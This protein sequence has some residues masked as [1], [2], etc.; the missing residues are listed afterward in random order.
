VRYHVIG[1]EDTVLGFR[2]AGVTGDVVGTADEARA[3]LERA[4]RQSDVGIVIIT[5]AMADLIRADVNKVRFGVEV[6]LVVEV[7]GPGGPS[8]RRKDL[9]SLIQEAV[10]IRV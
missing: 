5:D 1:D 8:P 3:A 2:F 6:P 9:L 10:G 7:A 4:L